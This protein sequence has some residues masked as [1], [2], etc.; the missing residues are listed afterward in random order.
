MWNEKLEQRAAKMRARF[1][2]MAEALRTEAEKQG[3]KTPGDQYVAA[4]ISKEARLAGLKKSWE[5]KRAQGDAH[6]MSVIELEANNLQAG[7]TFRD[8]SK[9]T[10]YPPCPRCNGSRLE[11]TIRAGLAR[12]I[13]R[14]RCLQC[15]GTFSGPTVVVKLEEQDYEMICY[16][17]GSKNTKRQGRGSNETRT[18]RMGLCLSCD[19]KF[20]QGG[21]KDLQKYHL[22]L[23]KRIIE[24]DLPEDVEAEVLQTATMDVLIGKGYCWSVEL[25]TSDA[26]RNVR[27]EWGQRGSDHPKFREQMGQKKYD[28]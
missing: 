5:R 14:F 28:D 8:P 27:G 16:H 24:L 22:L 19:K 20:V 2:R 3:I 4:R 26:F 17:C 9:R 13:Q 1:E 11:G 6:R 21:V 23:E 18:G 15:R 7:R 10:A 12:G 25:K